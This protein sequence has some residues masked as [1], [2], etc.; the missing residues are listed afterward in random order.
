MRYDMQVT[1]LE[2]KKAKQLHSLMPHPFKEVQRLGAGVRA[3][4][5]QHRHFRSPR[6]I[7]DDKRPRLMIPDYRELAS[8]SRPRLNCLPSHPS[9]S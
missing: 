2:G 1:V 5:K 6:C 3:K 8:T 7:M 9:S 4:H